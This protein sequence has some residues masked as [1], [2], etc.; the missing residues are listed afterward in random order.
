MAVEPE[1]ERLAQRFKEGDRLAFPALVEVWE[2][3]LYRMFY[4]MTGD[5][6]AAMD[7]AQEAFLRMYRGIGRWDG[8]ASFS[9]WMNRVAT[10]IGIDYL[11]KRGRSKEMTNP[12][13]GMDVGVMDPTPLE[14]E[15]E[16]KVRLDRL[17]RA[18]DSLPEGQ[19]VVMA[20]RH[21]QGLSLKEIAEVRN[22]ALGAVKSALFQAFRNLEKAVRSQQRS[23]T[24][25]RS[26]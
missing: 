26:G 24:D 9:T 15:E 23:K 18:M 7:L 20:L 16:K 4:G 10:N 22:C 11:R 21:Y 14:D 5:A 2:R 19:R 6:H 12:D 13:A 17:R 3:K 25:A 1:A 8:R